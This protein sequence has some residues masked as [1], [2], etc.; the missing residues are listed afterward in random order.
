MSEIKVPLPRFARYLKEAQHHQ[1][2]HLR[3]TEWLTSSFSF[4]DAFAYYE[5]PTDGIAIDPLSGPF[6]S[7]WRKLARN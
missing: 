5:P 1:F 2:P 4:D 6:T 3:E 7:W